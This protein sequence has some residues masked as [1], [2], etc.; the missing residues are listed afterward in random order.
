MLKKE[1]AR[2]HFPLM[3]HGIGCSRQVGGDRCACR[4]LTRVP[5]TWLGW[6]WG[7]RRVW[8]E[9]PPSRWCVRA[10]VAEVRYPGRKVRKALAGGVPSTGLEAG[11]GLRQE[12]RPFQ[13]GGV[14]V[15]RRTCA[16]WQV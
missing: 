6:E 9:L 5:G 4:V 2:L 16:C 10:E 15:S 1:L 13:T 14:C 12:G 11:A 7:R 8:A 3:W